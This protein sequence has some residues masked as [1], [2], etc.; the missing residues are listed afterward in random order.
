MQLQRYEG[1]PIVTPGGESWRR[2]VTFNPGVVLDGDTFYMLERACSSLA[3]LHCQFGLLRSRDGFRFRHVRREPVFTAAQLGTPQGTIEDPRVVKMGRT[4]VMTY[5]HRNYAS[6]CFPNGVG[7]PNY[8]NPTHVPPD[9]PNNYRSGIAVSRDLIRWRDLGLVTPKEVDDRDC[10]LFPEKIGGRYAML[11]RPMNYVGP[12]YG[13]RR[14]SIWISY[15]RDLR[16]WSDPELVAQPMNEAWESAKIGAGASPVRTKAGWLVIYHGVD[17][18]VTY[19][20]GA[21]LLDLRN[22]AKVV[23]RTRGF[24]LQ[25][26]A[27]YERTGLIIPNVVFPSANVV[28]D[29]RLYVYYG[30]AD[31][32]IGVAT[33]DV[34]A[35]VA[36]LLAGR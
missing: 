21:M 26:E 5:V 15:S 31:T 3:P 6:S 19:R 33:A 13:C 25:P 27:Y 36:D 9:D 12:K 14:P 32:C 30:C 24:I 16:K 8:H 35:L 20:A 2:V 1:N 28:R 7:V 18:A 10:V 34:D 23:A 22:P 11:R 17:A 4:F 29:G